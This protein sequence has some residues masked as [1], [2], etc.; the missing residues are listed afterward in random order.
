MSEQ[1]QKKWDSRY[2]NT[3]TAIAEPEPAY[4][5]HEYG[6][7]LPAGGNA[8][9]L[10]AGLGGNALY[11][12]QRGLHCTA[13]DIS[14]VAMERLAA[15]ASAKGLTITCQV[16]D[17]VAQPPAEQSFDVIVV[18][19]FLHRAL[20]DDI[21]AALRPGGLLYYQT[22]TRDKTDNTQGPSNPDFLLEPNELLQLFPDLIVRV[23]RE[24]GLV[25]DASRGLRNEACLVGEKR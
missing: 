6:Y 15:Q 7:L 4:V 12:A 25:G 16:R 1:E 11:L 17:V 20:C 10:A 13:W 14:A 3:A 8:L 9:D 19:R 18:S 2:R 23:Y 5:L 24:D 22:F 21:A